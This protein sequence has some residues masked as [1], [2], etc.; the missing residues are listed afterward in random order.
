MAQFPCEQHGA[1]Y[2][3]PQQTAYPAVVNGSS[4]LREKRRLCPDCFAAVQE[5]AQLHLVPGEQLIDFV[6]CAQC[7]GNFAPYAVFLTLFGK[8]VGR[9]DFWGRVCGPCLGGSLG[10]A[11]FG[12]Q[13]TLEAL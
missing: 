10:V 3:G 11:L 12:R 2:R 1:R 8:S 7:G 5:Y 4:V 13:A 6:V 9:E